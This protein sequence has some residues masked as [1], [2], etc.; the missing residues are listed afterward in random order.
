MKQGMSVDMSCALSNQMQANLQ[1]QIA[2]EIAQYAQ[3]QGIAMLSALGRTLSEAETN[4][5]QI[6]QARAKQTNLQEA[7]M[8]NLQQQE[9]SVGQTGGNVVI[10]SI[11]MEQSAEV[12]AQAIISSSGIAEA[13]SDIANKIDQKAETEETGPLDTFFGMIKSVVSSYVFMVVGIVVVAGLIMIFFV[14]YLFTTETGALLIKEGADI[15][16]TQIAKS[17]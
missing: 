8:Q 2:S 1:G 15:A 10:K 5:T 7:V 16:K 13:I 17:S 12:V 4:I 9:I 14:K 6:F 11:T 3:S